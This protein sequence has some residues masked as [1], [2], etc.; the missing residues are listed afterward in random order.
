MRGKHIVIV[1]IIVA[2]A[3][4]LFLM[5]KKPSSQ[6]AP[7]QAAGPL[8]LP[9]A[10]CVMR[11][12]TDFY[13][14]TGTTEAVDSVE[15][16]AR[17][18][19]YLK[20]IHFTDGQIVEEGQLLFT[21]EPEA[22]AARRDEAAAH[23]KAAQAESEQAWVDLQ[24]IQNAIASNAVSQQDLTRSR[25]VYETASAAVL[26]AQA[27]LAD[28]QLNLSYTEIRSP[29]R[30]RIGRHMAD[31]GNLV[32]PASRPVLTTVMRM[33]PMY[34]SFY[35]GEHLLKG[36]LMQRLQGGGEP[37]RMLVGLPDENG[38]P[39]EG[40]I[41]FLDNRVDTKTG[42]VYV[43]GELP[44]QDETL[45]PG[46]FV[47]I[48]LPIAQRPNAVLIPEKAIL[49]DLGGK[50][51]LAVGQGNVLERRGIVLGA[52]VDGM[53]VVMDGLDGSEMFIT[54][55]FHMARPGMPV[56]PLTG[57]GPPAGMPA[58]Q[59]APSAS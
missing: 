28:A 45:L 55:G 31:V 49:T 16:R 53:R 17:V 52:S 27:K 32:G 44:N 5:R 40:T 2:V 33:Q 4:G 8:P 1:L 25:A 11:D 18:E 41:C 39:H 24:R 37:L 56:T 13:D 42:T 47:R 35:M 50:Y 51:V 26:A 34:V 38:Y 43:R 57:D 12:V 3:A 14:F 29:I 59:A 19:G 30:G 46:M 6:P 22:F 7:A 58:G 10:R 23:L 15:I 21:I 48:R 9:A 20:G 54:G 36:S